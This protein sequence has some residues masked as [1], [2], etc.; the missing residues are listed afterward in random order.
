MNLIQIIT[1]HLI[2]HG[3]DIQYIQS[4]KQLTKFQNTKE[5]IRSNQLHKLMEKSFYFISL[6]DL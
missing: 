1:H 4:T 5:L 3:S 2:I 6:L